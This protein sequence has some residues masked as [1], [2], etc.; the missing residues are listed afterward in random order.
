MGDDIWE[1]IAAWQQHDEER[2]LELVA[3]HEAETSTEAGAARLFQRELQ[4]RQ[5]NG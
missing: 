5:S 3:Q 4:R 1:Q 2:N